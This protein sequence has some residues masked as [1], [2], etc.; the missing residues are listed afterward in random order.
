MRHPIGTRLHI[1]LDEV[2]FRDGQDPFEPKWAIAIDDDGRSHLLYGVR[3]EIP[4][5]VG[6]RAVMECRAEDRWVLVEELV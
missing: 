4:A 1:R 2:L 3:H 6:L 5:R